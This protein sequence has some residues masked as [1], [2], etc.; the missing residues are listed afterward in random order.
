MER[1]AKG[2]DYCDARGV[3]AARRKVGEQI[4]AGDCD[5]ALKGALATGDLQFAREVRDFCSTG[6]ENR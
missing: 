6:R 3:A 5:S 1:L 2:S 4:A